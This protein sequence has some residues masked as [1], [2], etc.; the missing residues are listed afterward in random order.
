MIQNKKYFCYEIFKN[1]SI[2]TKNNK[3]AYSPCSFYIGSVKETDEFDLESVWH[4]PELQQ[5]KRHIETDTPIPG[6]QVCYDAEARG[7]KSRRISVKE[8]YE[9]YRQQPEL[10]NQGPVSIDY[11]VGNLCNLKCAICGPSASISWVPDYQKLYPEKPVDAFLC[12][13]N[14]QIEVVDPVLL[15]SIQQIHFHGGG[16]PLLSDYHTNLMEKIKEAKGLSDVRI[17]YNT[18]GTYKVSD[19]VLGLWGESQLVELYFS[20]DDIG[21]R[22]NYQRTGAKWDEVVANMQWFKQ[23]MPSGH[24]FYINCVYSF[25]NIFYL[26][27]LLSWVASNFSSNRLGDA[28]QVFFQRCQTPHL[29]LVLTEELQQLLLT[30]FSKHTRLVELVRSLPVNHD[31][32]IKKI[33]G[34]LEFAESLDTIRGNSFAQNHPEWY[35]LLKNATK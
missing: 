4:G 27:E 6:C 12:K 35:Q 31:I 34:F 2:V 7:Q 29:D 5:L 14:N 26:D 18:N 24:L 9:V 21:D 11:S 17:F 23:V 15:G 16:E 19:K 22:F 8:N 1:L 13:R 20:M 3:V 25:F 32:A 33:G 28:V 30:K 10:D